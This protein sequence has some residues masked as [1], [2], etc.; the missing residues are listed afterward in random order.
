MIAAN[1]DVNFVNEDHTPALLKVVMG[2]NEA[3]VRVLIQARANPDQKNMYGVS[4]LLY[5]R[6][7]STTSEGLSAILPLLEAAAI[8]QPATI[9]AITADIVQRWILAATDGDTQ[10]LRWLLN[11]HRTALL[12]R[13]DEDGNTA[14]FTAWY[15]LYCYYY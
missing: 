11:R 3:L 13:C 5:A 6:Q 7:A 14:L 15:S 12:D 10:T 1:A 4:A 9:E 2:R 8:S